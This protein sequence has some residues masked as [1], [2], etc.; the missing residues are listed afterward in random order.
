MKNKSLCQDK[1]NTQLSQTMWLISLSY[2]SLVFYFRFLE[3]LESAELHGVIFFET[4]V[5]YVST[6]HLFVYFAECRWIFCSR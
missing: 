5:N 2:H 3:I 6:E 4:V 1:N